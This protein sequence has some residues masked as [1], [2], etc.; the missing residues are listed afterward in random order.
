MSIL[1]NLLAA[2]KA[3]NLRPI[4]ELDRKLFHEKLSIWREWLKNMDSNSSYWEK[5]SLV[6]KLKSISVPVLHLQAKDEWKDDALKGYQIV[7]NGSSSEKIKKEHRFVLGKHS[8]GGAICNPMA[9]NNVG[10][11]IRGYLNKYLSSS[12]IC[13]DNRPTILYYIQNADQWGQAKKWPIHDKL[14]HFY[15]DRGKKKEMHLLTTS[16]PSKENSLSYDYDP[17]RDNIFKGKAGAL[18]YSSKKLVSS[19]DI[20]GIIKAKL[21]ISID[22]PDTDIFLTLYEILASGK[23]K[24]IRSSS[25]RLRFRKSFSSPKDFEPGKIE[26]IT[27][28][29]PAV[30]YRVS[31]GSKLALQI[32]STEYS[33]FE[34]SNMGMKSDIRKETKTQKVKVKILNG[35]AYSSC[36]VIPVIQAK[37]ARKSSG[38][39][40][41]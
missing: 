5:R 21:Y 36:I 28:P 20:A 27:I 3:T 25:L 12:D 4:G 13:L 16:L 10:H 15:M 2:D 30:V 11:L 24:L 8:H 1:R 19:M 6:D 14:I 39:Q 34:N 18:N 22:T 41:K 9:K 32:K 7:L 23:S 26:K 17:K 40:Q 37:K 33:Y 38:K 29:F 31:S 35:S